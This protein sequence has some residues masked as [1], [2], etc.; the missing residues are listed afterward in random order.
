MY[1]LGILS[2][3]ALKS[4]RSWWRSDRFLVL[5]RISLLGHASPRS[6][7]RLVELE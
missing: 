2:F 4:A 3:G 7:C 5:D 6:G 1:T